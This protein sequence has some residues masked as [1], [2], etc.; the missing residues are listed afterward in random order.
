MADTAE[1][2]SQRPTANHGGIEVDASSFTAPPRPAERAEACVLNLCPLCDSTFVYP[3]DWA[4]CPDGHWS[5]S[6]RCPECEWRGGGFYKQAL[7]DRFDEALER[8]TE[9]LLD[10]LNT[11]AKANMEDQVNR[12][13]RALW[14]DM[15]LPEDF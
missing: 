7:V 11:L 14:A 2:V 4:P 10:D 6:L 9:Q 1:E 8:G 3:I 15:V 13:A 5:V 12:F